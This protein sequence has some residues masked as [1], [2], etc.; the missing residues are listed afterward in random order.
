MKKMVTLFKGLSVLIVVCVMVCGCNTLGETV[1]H[2]EL[3]TYEKPF[4]RV[5]LTAL[6]AIE[7]NSEWDL[8]STNKM[9]GLILVRASDFMRE[10]AATVVIKR[11]NRM[12]TS[13][14]LAKESQSIRG[15]ESL[16]KSI[17][18]SLML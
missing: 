10:D 1:I 17:D 4:D 13:I 15:V 11:L 18:K 14:E 9:E 5:Y 3:F 6:E 2:D 16:L 8:V 7:E 12:Q